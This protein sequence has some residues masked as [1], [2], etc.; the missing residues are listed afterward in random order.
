MKTTQAMQVRVGLFILLSLTVL[1]GTIFMLGKERRLFENRVVYKIH[2]SRINGLKE[3]A[4]VN[5]SGVTV[6]S[7]ESLTIP[8][9]LR[10][11]YIEIRIKVAGAVAPRIRTD[12][13]ARIRTQG[14][15]GDKFIDLSGG[16][17]HRDRKSV[18]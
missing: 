5:L 17:I 9:D 12:T 2:Y 8:Q 16:S 1:G 13:V 4:P 3:G 11:K 10:Q 6:G 15:L 18:V 14:L 7:V